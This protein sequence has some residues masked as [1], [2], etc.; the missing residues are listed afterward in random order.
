MNT[1]DE[2]MLALPTLGCAHS[3][4]HA[5][6][7]TWRAGVRD[8]VLASVAGFVATAA[9]STCAGQVPTLPPG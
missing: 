2:R 7:E 9:R 6:F 4:G 3:D 5:G 8:T 1:V